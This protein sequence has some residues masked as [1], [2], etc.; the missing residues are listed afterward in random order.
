[1]KKVDDSSFGPLATK[2]GVITI[3]PSNFIGMFLNLM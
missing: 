3:P 2:N 1:M